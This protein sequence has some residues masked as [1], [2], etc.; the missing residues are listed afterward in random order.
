M[1]KTLLFSAFLSLIA[2]QEQP[3]SSAV[4]KSATGNCSVTAEELEASLIGKTLNAAAGFNSCFVVTD[5]IVGDEGVQWKA[6]AFSLNGNL[7]FLAESTDENV[8][9]VNRITIE[10]TH[11]ATKNGIKVGDDAKKLLPFMNAEMPALPDGYLGVLDKDNN[12][13][14]YQL[15]SEDFPD[16]LEQEIAG[17]VKK[18]PETMKVTAIVIDGI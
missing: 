13:T 15:N 7:E 8:D 17:D 5:T 6:K 3:A 14:L 11:I 9:A 4:Q 18:I 10:G 1:K 12:K 16:T 2:C